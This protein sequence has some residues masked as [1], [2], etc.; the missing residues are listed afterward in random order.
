[1]KLED[2]RRSPYPPPTQPSPDHVEK[3]YRVPPPPPPP[4]PQAPP[5]PSKPG[6]PDAHGE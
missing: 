2:E 6:P 5:E 3:G 1:M 4:P